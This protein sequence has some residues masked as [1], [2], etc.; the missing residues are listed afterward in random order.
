MNLTTNELIELRLKVEGIKEAGKIEELLEKKSPYQRLEEVTERLPDNIAIKYYGNNITYR[1]FKI[2]VDRL[3]KG[4]AEIGVKAY[5][6]VAVS[7]LATPYAIAAF[8]ALDKIGATMHMINPAGDEEDLK[9]KIKDAKTTVF[10]GTDIA[11]SKRNARILSE[12]G[13]EKIVLTALTD[14]LPRTLNSNLIK[15]LFISK[16]KG[17]SDRKYDGKNL[18][19]F[20]QLLERGKNS[21]IDI[22]IN[23][24][25]NRQVVVSYTSGTTGESKG[26]SATVTKGD[27]MVQVM[28]MTEIGRF[29]PGDTM[30]TTFPLWINYAL[31]NMMHEPISLGASVAL[32]PIF[33]PKNLSELNKLY[34]F[35]HWLTI[36]PYIKRMVEMDKPMDCSKWNI[37][38]T[39]GSELDMDTKLAADTYI[40][41]NGG[42]AKVAEGLG[43]TEGLGSIAYG[44]NENPTPGSF[45]VPCIGN[46]IRI[47]PIG[48]KIIDPTTVEE[49][50][51]GRE[52]VG[53]V[54]QYSPAMTTGYHEK[55]EL[56]EAS[57][58]R[59]K[60]GALWYRSGDLASRNERGEFFF[61]GR[62]NGI[63]LTLT[64][65]GQP[66]KI[67]PVKVKKAIQQLPEIDMC[68]VITVP[69]K[70]RENIPVAFI[71]LKP[72]MKMN[73]INNRIIDH[74]ESMVPEYMVPRTIIPIEYMPMNANQKPSSQKLQEIYNE[75]TASQVIESGYRR[76]RIKGR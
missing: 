4:F 71:V 7:L 68:E 10:I 64:K 49:L 45:G 36:P 6:R 22:N 63:V 65:S 35:N 57:F 66:A 8:Y 44:Y 20:T 41:K 2:I 61:E 13:I 39:G 43:S 34:E 37:I 38:V 60:N 56:T 17:V 54:Y 3:A 47:V 52:H 55:P 11:Y 16:A 27:A 15:M 62:L 18:I 5:D 58:I 31:W 24:D 50:P 19:N 40:S 29:L 12:C 28:G 73:N 30:L 72:G 59:D 32:A 46:I 67:Y 75:F 14:A 69:D 23:T 26:C 76:V 53:E 21:P 51:L 25:P 33:K 42:K 74:C 48:E 1:N 70:K 9:H